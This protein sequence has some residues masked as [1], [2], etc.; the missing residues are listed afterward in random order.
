VN[1]NLGNKAYPQ[2]SF[3]PLMVEKVQMMFEF[4]LEPL[5]VIW[6]FLPA[7]RGVEA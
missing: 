6:M 1:S 2:S 4:E 5:F 3:H 7:L